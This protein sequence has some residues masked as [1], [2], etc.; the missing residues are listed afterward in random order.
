MS[1]ILYVFDKTDADIQDA[2]TYADKENL[3]SVAIRALTDAMRHETETPANVHLLMGMDDPVFGFDEP[4]AIAS[5]I[6]KWNESLQIEFLAAVSAYDTEQARTGIA[7]IDSK[8]S[9]R[10]ASA[11]QALDNTADMDSTQI[12]YLSRYGIV[13][14]VLTKDDIDELA[15]HPEHVALF[16][17]YFQ[18]ETSST[19]PQWNF[20]FQPRL[21][22]FFTWL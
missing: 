21:R 9:H 8:F 5:Y 4:Q 15:A 3:V 22:Q 20:P 14:S 6:K 2:I 10:L 1:L 18:R 17:V 11:A 16:K 12:V 19:S 13:K 7:P